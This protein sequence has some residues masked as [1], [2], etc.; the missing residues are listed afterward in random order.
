MEG[1]IQVSPGPSGAAAS[2]IPDVVR[3]PT[4]LPH[5]IPTRGGQVVS[6]NLDTIEAK[7][8]LD[9]ETTY[10]FWT[11]NGKVPGSLLRVRVGDMAEVHL[12]NAVDSVMTHSIDFHAATG[13]GGGQN[14]RRPK[15]A[16]RASSPSR[17]SFRA[18]SPSI[19]ADE[20]CCNKVVAF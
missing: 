2:A 5:P 12:K 7:G 3:D 16:T 15:R 11:F 20:S 18:Y 6:I 19:S 9:D 17:H 14:L 1:R 13:P 8:Q 4:D 10:D